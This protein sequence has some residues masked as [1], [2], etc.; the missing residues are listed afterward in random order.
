MAVGYTPGSPEQV[1]TDIVG[2][3][4]YQIV[5]IDLGGAGT[6]SGLSTSNPLPISG[7]YFEDSE[8]A[9]GDRGLLLLGVR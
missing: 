2:G 4:H 7:S 9:S 3:A 6:S 5:K 1:A 8:H